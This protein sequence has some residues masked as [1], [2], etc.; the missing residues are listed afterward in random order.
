VLMDGMRHCVK[1]QAYFGGGG[2]GFHRFQPCHTNTI[3]TG[4][5]TGFFFPSIA[6]VDNCWLDTN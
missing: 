1:A 2:K 5:C 3:Q 6:A 4:Y